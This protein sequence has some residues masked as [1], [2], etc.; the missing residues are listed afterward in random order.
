M[1]HS[2]KAGTDSLPY[3]VDAHS[4]WMESEIAKHTVNLKTP[5][6]IWQGDLLLQI[7]LHQV[8]GAVVAFA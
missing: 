7:Q 2:S 5:D 1:G 6:T 8:E 3:I 4:I